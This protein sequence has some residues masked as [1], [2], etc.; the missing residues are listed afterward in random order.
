VARDYHD[1]MGVLLAR[2]SLY[3]ELVRR[4]LD[5][6]ASPETRAFMGKIA[7]GAQA[8]TRRTREFLWVLDPRRDR[9]GDLLAQLDEAGRA[10]FEDTSTKFQVEATDTATS[11]TRL[12]PEAKRHLV[13]LFQE[14]MHNA[15][16]HASASSV[17][18]SAHR[19]DGSV[20]IELR[21]DGRGIETS[22]D[23]G[24]SRGA[25][26]QGLGNL[27]SRAA[28]ARGE[29]FVVGTPGEGTSVRFEGRVEQ[30]SPEWGSARGGAPS[31]TVER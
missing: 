11:D 7:A 10:L 29:I 12:G 13:L 9:V 27:R 4:D 19:V 22:A 25:T 24:T 16:K 31:A 26:G 21:D 17:V 20:V 3:A 8:L 2:I 23:M 14:A 1:E 30:L 28:E 15:H 5:G 6:N 18:L